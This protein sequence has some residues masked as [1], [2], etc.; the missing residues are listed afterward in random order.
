[1]KYHTGELLV[2]NVD[3]VKVINRINPNEK[4]SIENPKGSG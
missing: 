4:L 3:W 2:Q 1:M